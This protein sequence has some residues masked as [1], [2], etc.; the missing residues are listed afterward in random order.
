MYSELT[1]KFNV[2]IDGFSTKSFKKTNGET[3]ETNILKGIEIPTSPVPFGKYSERSI[4][5]PV[6]HSEAGM[7]MLEIFDKIYPNLPKLKSR[8]YYAEIEAVMNGNTRNGIISYWSP[9]IKSIKFIEIDEETKEIIKT[10]C[11]DPMDGVGL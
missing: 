2:L 10:M 7:P 6:R 8:E 4:E 5:F 3:M 11:V 9:V 1:V